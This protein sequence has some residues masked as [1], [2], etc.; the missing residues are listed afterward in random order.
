M[1][2]SRPLTLAL[3]LGLGLG[4]G[5]PARADEVAVPVALQVELLVKVASYDRNLASRAGPRLRTLILTKDKSD[6]STRTAAQFKEALAGKGPV[7]GLDHEEEVVPFT[8]LP[9]LVETCRT[10]RPAIIYVTAGFADGEYAAIGQALD[11]VAV[12]SVAAEASAVRKGIV[13]GFDLVSGKPKLLV[14]LPRAI[15][16]HVDLSANVLRLMTVYQ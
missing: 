2:P 13:L 5:T 6:V 11:G 15:R 4:L 14:D 8:T 12:L 7:A 9:A 10:R 3:L 16:Q 1:A